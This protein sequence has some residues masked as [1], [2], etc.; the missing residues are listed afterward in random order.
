MS[1]KPIYISRHACKQHTWIQEA[2]AQVIQ[3]VRNCQIPSKP[4]QWC[5]TQYSTSNKAHRNACPVLWMCGHLLSKYSTLKPSGQIALHGYDWSRRTYEGRRGAGI[6][7]QLYGAIDLSDPDGSQPNFDG[8]SSRD[9]GRHDGKE[10]Q[11][12][13]GQPRPLKVAQRS[14]QGNNDHQKSWW[15]K[16]KDKGYKANDRG[17]DLRSVVKALGRLVL[18]QEDSL[19]VMQLDCQ[20][21]IFTRNPAKGHWHGRPKKGN[22]GRKHRSRC[23]SRTP[24]KWWSS[25]TSSSSIPT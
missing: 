14:R 15:D 8:G 16:E 22:T 10:G 12:G 11:R 24:S 4:C 9:A 23:P 19:S 5:R 2:N 7:S 6:L 3:W 1:C 20:F 13:S 18:R 21:I 25:C 17:Q